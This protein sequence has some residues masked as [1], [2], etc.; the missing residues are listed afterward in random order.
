MG[1]EIITVS[2][3]IF[4]L[5]IFALVFTIDLHWWVEGCHQLKRRTRRLVSQT[6]GRETSK[7]VSFTLFSGE[8]YTWTLVSSLGGTPTSGHSLNSLFDSAPFLWALISFT[9]ASFGVPPLGY[10]R[11]RDRCVAPRPHD[12]RLSPRVAL[13]ALL[14]AVKITSVRRFPTRFPVAPA[15]TPTAV[16]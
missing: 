5:L 7:R 9:G 8:V 11:V 3:P 15:H 12:D 14:G 16:T 1:T 4:Y 13:T 2:L 6:D 10:Q